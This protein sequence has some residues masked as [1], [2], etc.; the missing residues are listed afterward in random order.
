MTRLRVPC[1]LAFGAISLAATT[2]LAQND[3]TAK[4]ET[5]TSEINFSSHDGHAMFGKLVLPPSG[6]PRA[7]VLYVQTAE[8]ATVDMKR[9]L[10]ATA[11]FNYFDL[12]REKL[13]PKG[14]GFFSYEG[15]GIRMGVRLPRFE[16]IDWDV[17]NTGTLENKAQDVLSAID[18]VRKQ[19][20]C[21]DAPIVLMGTS[22]GTLVAA[23]A[24]SL[25]PNA[26]AGLILY[27]VLA[28]NMRENF[29]YIM[30]DGAFLV[31]RLM[32]DGDQDGKI[33]KEEFEKDPHRYRALVLR[34]LDFGIWDKN[35]DG[36][37][38]AD[39]MGLVTKPLLDAIDSNHY[40][41]LQGWSTASAG[42]S[43]PK[44]WFKDHFAHQPIWTF[45]SRLDIPV[46]CFH[47]A[48][49]TNTPIAAVRKLEEQAEAAGKSRMEFHYFD[50]LDHSLNIMEHF[51]T[52]RMPKGHAAIFE[53][54][55]RFAAQQSAEK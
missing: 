15:R 2:A 12:Y 24:A 8:G 30:T 10:S 42:V 22:E 37:F 49:D 50:E 43:V 29:R 3:K 40:E 23:E 13:P 38:T 51:R 18:A 33:T 7:I 53:F 31:Y 34:N 48:M 36:Q 28:S 45:L 47:G 27:A 46:A 26:V 19:P 44:D 20:G 54:V 35:S 17:F 4:P 16:T 41:V 52:G 11:T 39:E 5:R 14:V 9:P 21:E 25:R 32:F 6:A 55:D 1:V